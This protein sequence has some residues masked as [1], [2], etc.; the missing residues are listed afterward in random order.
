M[1][2]GTEKLLR[3][4]NE[5]FEKRVKEIR[6]AKDNTHITGTKYYVSADGDDNNDGKSESTP[7]K[8]LRKVSCAKFQHG[9]GVLFR[10]GDVFRG[11]VP[12]TCDGVT[13]GA[14]GSGDKPILCAGDKD[15]ADK[16]LWTLYDK[17]NNIWKCTE[18]TLD[19]GTIVFD[20]G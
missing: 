14:Y 2:K 11:Y 8:S 6:N 4:Y 17:D 7:W 5:L 18:K 10:R 19:V 1:I 3:E 15:Y 12:N 16:S 13:Y 9:D 20:G